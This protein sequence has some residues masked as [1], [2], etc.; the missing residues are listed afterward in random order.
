MCKYTFKSGNKCQE[1]DYGNYDY[2]ILHVDIPK[3]PES[4]DF[5]K[6]EELKKQKIQEK[7]QANDFNFEGLKIFELELSNFNSNGDVNFSNCFVYF[8]LSLECITTKGSLL[9]SDSSVSGCLNLGDVEIGG[10]LD[11]K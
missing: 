9:F 7:I 2:C 10:N 3:D 8:N 4:D 11:L 5:S 1:A 6:L